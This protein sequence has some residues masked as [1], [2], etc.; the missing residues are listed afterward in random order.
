MANETSEQ[1]KL[2]YQIRILDLPGSIP[3]GQSSLPL[4]KED[5][6][7]AEE[8]RSDAAMIKEAY[9]N[10][11]LS[12]SFVASRGLIGS[13]NM[14]EL[15][16][17]AEVQVI[18]WK[19]SDQLRSHLGIPL[20][21]E[22]FYSMLSSVQQSIW[23]GAKLF[24]IDPV[25]DTPMDAAIAMSAIINSQIR[26]CGYK[27]LPLKTEM[28]SVLYDGFLYGT[29]TAIIG[30]EV[31]TYKT[32]KKAFKLASQTVAT[33]SGATYEVPVEQEDEMIESTPTTVEINAPH[34]QHVP[35]RRLRVAPDCRRSQIRTA[36][37]AGMLMY[38]SSHDLDKL[39][40]TEGFNIPTRQQ[41]IQLTTPQKMDSTST[42]ALDTQGSN[43]ANPIFQQTTTPQKAY[44]ENYADGGTFDP[45]GKKFEV[46]DYWTD[47]RHAMILENQFCLLNEANDDHQLPFLSFAYKEA[48]DSLY[49][50]GL[51]F[52][53][54]DFQRICVGIVNAFFD[55]LNLN[56]M[57]VYTA[58][59][60]MANY[61]QNQW[62]FP[63]KVFKSD[64]Q[65]KMEPLTRNAIDPKEPLA[66]VAQI[67]EWASQ[68][69][70]AGTGILGANP[71]TPGDVRTKQ[72]VQL[73][74]GGE[75]TKAQDLMDVISDQI[76]VPFLE[77]CVENNRK[78]KPSQIRLLLSQELEKANKDIH[79]SPVDILNG[80]YRLSI[81]AGTK[82][83]ARLSLNQSLGFIE[84]MLQAPGMAEMLAVQAMKLDFQAMITALF[85]STGYPYREQMVKP[86]TDEDKARLAASQ[87]KPDRTMET[88]AAKTASKKEIDEAQTENRLLLKTGESTLKSQASAQDHEQQLGRNVITD[89]LARSQ[90]QNL[91]RSDSLYQRAGNYPA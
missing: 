67:K 47:D 23:S 21:A 81:T 45:L 30:W 60:G 9:N 20:L 56:L 76:L 86:M 79:I 57:G 22:H 5:I 85:E 88:I 65:N 63:G 2:L 55:D 70:G 78:L 59:A 41:L 11:V 33:G 64:G 72:N 87:G 90:R 83:A 4:Q 61:A 51:G 80:L 54:A 48:P 8:D 10:R 37:W 26:H 49:G 7:F 18:K 53:L 84:S 39:R 68:I 89:A 43:T 25:S 3:P 12:E 73:M 42:N 69:S 44:P 29:G 62:I 19:N 17:R 35:I 16:L 58:P 6:G 46:F 15:M 1:Q 71:G 50:Y 77:Y 36:T 14:V 38:M 74:A 27:R 24:Q 32:M 66:V 31:K 91:E 40:N 75:A 82:L 28:R 34:F 13:W 52:W